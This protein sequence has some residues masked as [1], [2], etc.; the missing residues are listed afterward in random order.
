MLLALTMPEHAPIEDGITDALFISTRYIYDV[1][2]CSSI[3]WLTF[4]AILTSMPLSRY[5]PG[6]LLRP[7]AARR[8]DLLVDAVS[9]H[10]SAPGDFLKGVHHGGLDLNAR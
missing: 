10:S 3:R 4:L 9:L 2:I 1:M 8:F 5:Q 6:T 7:A